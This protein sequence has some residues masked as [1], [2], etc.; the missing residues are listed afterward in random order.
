MEW[1]LLIPEIKNFKFP[2]IPPEYN[3]TLP[4][5]TKSINILDHG[6]CTIKGSRKLREFSFSCFF[7]AQEYSFCLCKP[8]GIWDYVKWI[9]GAYKKGSICRFIITTTDV[10]LW[11]IVDEFSYGQKQDGDIYYSLKLKEYRE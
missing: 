8:F 2:I 1:W 7:P 5:N 9:K 11:C 10:D 3:Y 4:S 6:E